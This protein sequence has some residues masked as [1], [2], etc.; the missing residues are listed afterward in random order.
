MNATVE[1]IQ[2]LK[3]LKVRIFYEKDGTIYHA[4]FSGKS[5]LEIV[6]KMLDKG[7]VFGDIRRVEDV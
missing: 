4:E 3:K 2:K 5:E 6:F 1:L 7:I